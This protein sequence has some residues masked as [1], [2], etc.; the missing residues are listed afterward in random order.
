M[1]FNLK[2]PNEV[3]A[4][5][6]YLENL[7]EHQ[8]RV[9]ITKKSPIRSLAQN[10]YC[11]LCLG[12]FATEF[13]YTIDEIKHDIFKKKVNPEIFIRKR[14]N[15]RGEEIT[16]V[17]STAEL[18]TAEMNTALERFRNYSAME[19]Q[20]YIPAPNET[21]FLEFVEREIERCKE[22]V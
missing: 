3:K 4:A 22:F 12:F 1:I 6:A 9:E 20:F 2:F 8:A 21:Q 19:C 14:I 13:G 15:K 17:R 5:Y 10:R 18:T 7:E 11:Y 16:Y